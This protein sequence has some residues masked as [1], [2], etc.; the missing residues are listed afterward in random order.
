MAETSQT[1][2]SL[3]AQITRTSRV[4]AAAALLRERRARDLS[5]QRLVRLRCFG[6]ASSIVRAARMRRLM[7]ERRP[8]QQVWTAFV[9]IRNTVVA[10][11]RA[12]HVGQILPRMLM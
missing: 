4:L 12:L 11:R 7:S 2:K 5:F 6:H 3:N 9:C 8:N 10:G 1:P